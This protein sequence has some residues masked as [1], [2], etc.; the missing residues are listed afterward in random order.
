MQLNSISTSSSVKLPE[1]KNRQKVLITE[2]DD[3]GFAKEQANKI[4]RGIYLRR[5]L[6]L[7]PWEKDSFNNIYKSSGKSNHQILKYLKL[8]INSGK[9]LNINDLSNSNYYKDYEIKTINDSREISKEIKLNSEIRRK[10]RQPSANI[11]AYTIETKEQCKI[12]MLADVIKLEKEKMKQKLLEYE[13][14][15]QNENNILDKDISNF[16]K[17]T[18]NEALKR[19]QNNQYI[20]YIELNRKKLMLK[21]KQLAQETSTL[22]I[23]IIKVLRRIND[24]KIYVN[25]I[26]KLFGGEPELAKIDLDNYNFSN[27]KENEIN[28][29]TQ[30]IENEMNKNDKQENI[31]VNSAEED[32]IKN[33]DKLDIVFKVMEENIM[34]TLAQKEKIR[35]EIISIKENGENEI[36]YLKQ[37]IEK[38]EK[39]YEEFLKEYKVEKNT[40][41]SISF[42]SEKYNNFVR[43]LHMELF[44]SSKN[45]IIKNKNDIDEYNV[46]DKIIKPTLKLITNKERKIDSL[47]IEMEKLSNE[48]KDLF[49]KSV[50]KI[51]NENK[52]VK[53][54]EEKNNRDIANS[55]KNTKILDKIN[56][57]IITGKHKYKMPVPLSIIKKRRNEKKELETEPIEYKMLHY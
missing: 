24:T 32:L 3:M 22:K 9:T 25:F 33:M 35:N 28:S 49:N 36:E 55:I 16:E 1:L 41:D 46:I 17:F 15:L 18:T 54:Y 5:Q 34:K 29:L 11:K 26:H 14:A 45:T 40:I 4:T 20:N 48:D 51:K 12:N 23:E 50:I 2:P 19:Q 27:L 8:R 13:K 7:K 47:I 53:Y 56:K 57:V 44:E 39:E 21:I 38:R 52:I 10:F 43:Q 30:M 42:S 6:N 37:L 31:L